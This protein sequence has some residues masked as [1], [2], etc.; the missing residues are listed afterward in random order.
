MKKYYLHNGIASSGPFS[1]EDL[2]IKQITKTTPVWFEGMEKWKY[3]KDLEELHPLLNEVASPL[4]QEKEMHYNETQ[5]HSKESKNT[6]FGISKNTFLA[7]SLILFLIIFTLI[8]NVFQKQRSEELEAKN[9]KTE[10][11][12]QQYLLQQKVIEEQ[13]ILLKQHEQAEAERSSNEKKISINSRLNT[14]ASEMAIVKENL[15]LA[16]EKLKET[17]EFK[18]LRSQAQKTKEIESINEEIYSLEKKL[19]VLNQESYRLKL[20]LE[21][22]K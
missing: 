6:I 13:K 7:T 10:N 20:E 8:F 14:I 2:K 12:N 5:S 21:K 18:I 9:K 22:I 3:A 1:L 17:N 16:K 11:E 4:S 19:A 15:A